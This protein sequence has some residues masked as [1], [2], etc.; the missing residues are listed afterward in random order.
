[1]NE[2]SEVTLISSKDHIPLLNSDVDTDILNMMASQSFLV[3][4]CLQK[5][6]DKINLLTSVFLK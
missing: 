5:I 2:A 4:E 6:L 1:M 3:A